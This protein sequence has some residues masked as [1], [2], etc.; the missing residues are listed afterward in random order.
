MHTVGEQR[1][2]LLDDLSMPHVPPAPYAALI[3]FCDALQA[4][5]Q[6]KKKTV[7]GRVTSSCSAVLPKRMPKQLE[8]GMKQYPWLVPAFVMS[9]LIV[10]LVLIFLIYG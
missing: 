2:F 1:S 4:R 10:V 8:A 5:A 9:L 3:C 7:W 6:Q